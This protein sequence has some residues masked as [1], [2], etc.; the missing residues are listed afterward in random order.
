MATL[1]IAAAPAVA[2]TSTTTTT[3][4]PA[5]DTA[6]PAAA[7]P[8]ETLVDLA[9]IKELRDAIVAAEKAAAKPAVQKTE[10]QKQAEAAAI[11]RH[12]DAFM[13]RVR[14]R[15]AEQPQG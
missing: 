5:T 3:T 9:I 6:P 10:E 7:M 14:E 11:A 8:G 12:R 1:L 4:E 13:A 15:L 2:Q